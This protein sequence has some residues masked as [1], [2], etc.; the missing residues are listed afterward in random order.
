[1]DEQGQPARASRSSASIAA[2]GPFIASAL[3]AIA[4]F[5]VGRYVLGLQSAPPVYI[6]T[7]GIVGGLFGTVWVMIS[8]YAPIEAARYSSSW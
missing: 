1:M 8:A 2:Q 3:G 5:T 7:G 4:G 6:L